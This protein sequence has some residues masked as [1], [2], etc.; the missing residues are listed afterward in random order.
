MRLNDKSDVTK[1]KQTSKY[2][3]IPASAVKGPGR[4]GEFPVVPGCVFDES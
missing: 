3:P 4:A 2:A 1:P